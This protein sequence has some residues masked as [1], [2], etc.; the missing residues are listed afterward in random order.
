MSRRRTTD[1]EFGRLQY[2]DQSESPDAKIGIALFP[3]SAMRTGRW[4]G[5]NSYHVGLSLSFPLPRRSPEAGVVFVS[6]ARYG[7]WDDLGFGLW[8]CRT[9]GHWRACRGAHGDG[10]CVLHR[11]VEASRIEARRNVL[12]APPARK[13][14][15]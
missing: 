5:G 7:N 2:A 4:G 1:I 3:V 8:A 11:A 10:H 13:W 15:G 9:H 6:G 14:A 12:D